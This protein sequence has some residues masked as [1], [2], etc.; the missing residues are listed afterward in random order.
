MRRN[1]FD[2]VN[3]RD[4]VITDISQMQ[5][6]SDGRY[7]YD[8]SLIYKYDF[9][10]INVNS[11]HKSID[12]LAAQRLGDDNCYATILGL[13]KLSDTAFSLIFGGKTI[14]HGDIPYS[15]DVKVYLE[16]IPNVM[17]GQSKMHVM[18]DGN[19]TNTVSAVDEYIANS[20]TWLTPLWINEYSWISMGKYVVSIVDNVGD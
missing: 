14:I 20:T 4:G 16:I 3:N 5:K 11:G 15:H 9:G 19:I 1:L 8:G 17:S 7:L 2:L 12:Y 10:I 13:S 6:T 18:V